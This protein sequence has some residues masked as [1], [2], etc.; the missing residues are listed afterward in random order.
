MWSKFCAK[1]DV[2]KVWISEQI[3][4]N[5]QQNKRATFRHNI[6]TRGAGTQS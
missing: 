5:L 2:R 3:L 4:R 1:K 6:K